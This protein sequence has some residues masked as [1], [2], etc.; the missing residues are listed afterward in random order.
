MTE[1]GQHFFSC[2]WGTSS[3][4][5]RL[6]DA[7]GSVMCE[8]REPAGVKSIHDQA[9]THGAKNEAARAPFFASFLK[10]QLTAISSTVDPLVNPPLIISGMASSTIGWKE[11]PYLRL[12]QPLDGSGITTEEHRWPAPAWLGP[13]YLI[14]GL[15]TQWDI[16]RGEEIEILGLFA[17]PGLASFR[18]RSLLILPGTHS[19][20]VLIENGSIVDFRTFMTG[21][22]Y[23]ILGRHSILRASVNVDRESAELNES[24]FREG[25]E[26]V[27]NYG[28]AESLFRVRTR[29]VLDRVPPDQNSAFLSGL[30]L[31]DELS[32]VLPYSDGP[33][34]LASG[35]SVSHLYALAMRTLA[36]RK[37]EWHQLSP[38]QVEKATITAHRLL[39][40]RIQN[41]S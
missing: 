9:L 35:R 3:F 4:R 33:I 11:L 41:R 27:A 31:G 24:E 20:H 40:T 28:L 1:P 15:A 10:E 34:L 29:A 37:L 7:N 14:S 26:W 38:A 19:K 17:D 21:E 30:L 8:R 36:D 6:V 23:D 13:T 16:M 12:P 39:L 18:G 22:L 2:D 25:V 5:L 32:H